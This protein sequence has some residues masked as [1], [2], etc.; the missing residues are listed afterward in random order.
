M[1]YLTTLSY[2][3]LTLVS[4]TT[5]DNLYPINYVNKY[6]RLDWR[7]FDSSLQKMN[8][9]LPRRKYVTRYRCMEYVSKR[10]DVAC[11]S[12]RYI[13]MVTYIISTILEQ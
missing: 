13:Q 6:G 3:W 7:D 8:L 12:V 9:T 2:F 4:F 10:S 11:P 5:S 1:R